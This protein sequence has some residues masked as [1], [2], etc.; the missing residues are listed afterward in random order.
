MSTLN[1]ED[2]LSSKYAVS[3]YDL[4]DTEYNNLHEKYLK[5]KEGE[6][7]MSFANYVEKTIGRKVIDSEREI[8]D[9]I[10]RNNGNLDEPCYFMCNAIKDLYKEWKDEV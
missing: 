6:N 9:K 5:Y 4:T 10:E 1:W 2:W 8:L 3:V 7:D